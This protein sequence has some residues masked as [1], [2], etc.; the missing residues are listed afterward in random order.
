MWMR[1][2]TMVLCFAMRRITAFRL[3]CTPSTTTLSWRAWLVI[4]AGL[5]LRASCEVIGDLQQQ[6]LGHSLDDSLPP[7]HALVGP[8]NH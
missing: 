2:G 4:A 3:R 5:A 8:T 7:H 6:R 1:N